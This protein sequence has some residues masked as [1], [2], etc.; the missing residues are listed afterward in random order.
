MP[1]VTTPA[2]FDECLDSGLPFEADEDLAAKMGFFPTTEDVMS[3]DEFFA[4][5]D[6]DEPDA[7]WRRCP[8][9]ERS[10]R[11]PEALP[12]NV[13]HAAGTYGV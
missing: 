4:P 12:T 2:E 13:R 10:L 5:P 7:D 3:D 1:I 8:N 9:A 6:P 11:R